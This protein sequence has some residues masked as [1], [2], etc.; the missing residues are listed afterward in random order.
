MGAPFTPGGGGMTPH[1][2]AQTPARW[3][4]GMT[5]SRGAMTPGRADYMSAMT[6]MHPGLTPS[7]TTPGFGT[8]TT[9]GTWG[10]PTPGGYGGPTPMGGSFQT[11]MGQTPYTPAGQTPYGAPTPHGVGTPGF[12]GGAPPPPPPVT[13]VRS[14]NGVILANDLVVKLG[15]G[16]QGVVA[17]VAPDGTVTVHLARDTDPSDGRISSADPGKTTTAAAASITTGEIAKKDR[18][19]VTDG[20]YRGQKGAVLGVDEADIVIHLDP[21]GGAEA[22]YEVLESKLLGRILQG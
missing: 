3:D 11:P 9:P 16:R 4:G 18:V 5:P 22:V 14:S 8:G 21:V 19:K 10:G 1:H 12:G 2:G 17:G 20:D 13:N 6:P 15:D 7:T